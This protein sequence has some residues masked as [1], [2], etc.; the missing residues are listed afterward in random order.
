MLN[1]AGRYHGRLRETLSRTYRDN[2]FP[3]DAVIMADN[4]RS[5][6]TRVPKMN[7]NALSLAL[8]L[9]AHPL[10]RSVFYPFTSRTSRHLYERALRRGGDG[11][12]GYLMTV[13]FHQRSD[14]V[15]FFEAWDVRKGPSLGTEFTLACPYTLL[16]H[17]AE[18]P[19][20]CSPLST[21]LDGADGARA[22]GCKVRGAGVHGSDQCWSRGHGRAAAERAGRP[23][24][25]GACR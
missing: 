11:G 3:P 9:Q 13:L 4:S 1:P 15:A 12:F 24:P 23:G 22:I 19:W 20:V 5:F 14:A 7:R 17:A 16:G 8:L 25:G 6:T 10:V 21:C 18:L 2:Y